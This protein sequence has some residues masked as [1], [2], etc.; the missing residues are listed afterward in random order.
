MHTQG[1]QLWLTPT[2]GQLGWTL[3]SAVTDTYP[4]P[5]DTWAD[6]SHL[7]PRAL[8]SAAFNPGSITTYFCAPLKSGIPP[9][10]DT[11]APARAAAEAKAGAI[12]W[13]ER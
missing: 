6:M 2:W 7:L 13:I 11:D 3:P 1:A 5:L 10:R 8:W 9:Q 12:A 4:E